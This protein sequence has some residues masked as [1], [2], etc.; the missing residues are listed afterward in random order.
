MGAAGFVAIGRDPEAPPKP[1]PS[2]GSHI[3][4]LDIEPTC[5]KVEIFSR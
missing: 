4:A 5:L 1:I 3:L 2:P